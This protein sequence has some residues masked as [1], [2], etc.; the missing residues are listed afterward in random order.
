MIFNY[1]F[2]LRKNIHHFDHSNFANGKV[3]GGVPKGNHS[4]LLRTLR[5]RDGKQTY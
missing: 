1:V 3:I 2:S 5:M 4:E